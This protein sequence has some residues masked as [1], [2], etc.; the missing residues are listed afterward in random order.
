MYPQN[1][2]SQIELSPC[3][4]NI[5][6]SN[7][8]ICLYYYYKDYFPIL[9]RPYSYLKLKKKKIASLII[10]IYFSIAHLNVN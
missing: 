3:S 6:L 10:K 1:I 9:P 7:L 8:V 5:D 4:L 2:D